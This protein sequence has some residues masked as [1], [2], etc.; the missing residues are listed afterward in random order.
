MNLSRLSERRFY[1]HPR[2]ANGNDPG[3]V[4]VS[5]SKQLPDGDFRITEYRWPDVVLW[6]VD[7][8]KFT[9]DE[10]QAA[11]LGNYDRSGTP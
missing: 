6:F 11:Y 8:D 2:I 10:R 3:G 4:T 9:P 5:K 1:F 7:Q